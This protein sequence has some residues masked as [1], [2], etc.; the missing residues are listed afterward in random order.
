MIKAVSYHILRLFLLVLIQVVIL[1]KVL[2]GGYINPYFYIMFIL[3]L[4]F[5]T[6]KWLLLIAGFFCGLT[7][8][9]FANTMGL[10]TAACVFMAFCRPGVLTMVSSRQDYEPGIKPLIRDLGFRWFFSYA[11]VL[12]T[13]HHLVLF[14]LEAFGFDEFFHTLLRSFLSII[15]TVI[16]LILT[17]YVVYRPGK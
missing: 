2:L 15:F 1:D 3:V 5:E 11:L 9:M 12:V 13:L 14:Y 6:P 17:Q 10:H 7:M 8:D 16:L 4:P